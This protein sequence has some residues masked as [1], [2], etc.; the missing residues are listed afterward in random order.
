MWNSHS[1]RDVLLSSEMCNASRN[2]RPGLW[3]LPAKKMVL[4]EE[5]R[6]M[7]KGRPLE[8]PPP[9]P[10]EFRFACEFQCTTFAI[11]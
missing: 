6:M 11:T 9:P 3:P 1:T 4:L 2:A 10:G 7:W 8:A 5:W